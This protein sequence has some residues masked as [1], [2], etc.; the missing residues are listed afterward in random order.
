MGEFLDEARS[1]MCERKC[2]SAPVLKWSS[3]RGLGLAV[4]GL[5]LSLRR[6]EWVVTQRGVKGAVCRD[7][8][9]LGVCRNTPA[10]RARPTTC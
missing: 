6:A 8:Q 4:C 7:P 10:R 9:R 2:P 3:V 1:Q 5:G